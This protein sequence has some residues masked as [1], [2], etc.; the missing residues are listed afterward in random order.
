M[1]QQ[2]KE[3]EE[4]A[5]DTVQTKSTIALTGQSSQRQKRTL[6]GFEDYVRIK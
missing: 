1:K 3:E 4:E 2:K 6:V 5:A